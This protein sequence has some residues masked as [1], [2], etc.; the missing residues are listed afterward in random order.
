[1]NWEALSVIGL[2][3]L[4]LG[5]LLF[6]PS[7]IWVK[8]RQKAIPRGRPGVVLTKTG[9]ALAVALVIALIGG[10]GMQHLAPESFLG[11][12]TKTGGG[13]LIFYVALGAI[14]LLTEATLKAIG[15]SLIRTGDSL[16]QS[17]PEKS[18]EA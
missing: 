8:R 12:L 13:R 18:K 10:V 2:F 15:I 9:W 14:F 5:V 6:I 16:P 3:T 17:K 11:K 4:A 1:M 7:W